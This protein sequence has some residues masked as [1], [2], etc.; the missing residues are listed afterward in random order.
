MQE[1]RHYRIFIAL[2]HR[3]EAWHGDMSFMRHKGGMAYELCALAELNMCT[4]FWVTGGSCRVSMLCSMNA[5]WS[6]DAVGQLKPYEEHTC[7]VTIDI[8]NRFQ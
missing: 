5:E 1:L 2:S 6:D 4:A 7:Q 3:S 8:R